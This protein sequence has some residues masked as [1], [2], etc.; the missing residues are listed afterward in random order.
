M[1]RGQKLVVEALDQQR[2]AEAREGRSRAHREIGAR[3]RVRVVPLQLDHQ[4]GAVL[5]IQQSEHVG[6]R[7]HPE[8]SEFA[9]VVI[10]HAAL[11]IGRAI[12]RCVV[13]DDRHPVGAQMHVKL[14][15]IGADL[16]RDPK[17]LHRI[18]GRFGARAAVRDDDRSLGRG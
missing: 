4:T 7:R 8:V 11:R 12:E 16:D 2:S 17:R 18:L 9:G 1:T 5:L 14:N 3:V 10:V 13:D 15:C 6:E